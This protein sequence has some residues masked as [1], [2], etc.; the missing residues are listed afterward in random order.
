MGEFR[1]FTWVLTDNI[2]SVISLFFLSFAIELP[3]L[4]AIDHGLLS[5]PLAGRVYSALDRCSGSSDL[6]VP[7]CSGEFAFQMA[8]T[9][10]TSM[11][12]MPCIEAL[13]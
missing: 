5:S 1:I 8:S 7:W 11:N 9:G 4:I 3:S 12:V 2:Q 6:S 13:Y 10:L